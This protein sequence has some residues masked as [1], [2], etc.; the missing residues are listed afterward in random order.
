MSQYVTVNELIKEIYF[1]SKI[2]E[3]EIDGISKENWN[4]LDK[5]KNTQRQDHLK[6]IFYLKRC[7]T[8]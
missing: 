5:V 8:L 3:R 2:D 1:I 6:V 7:L 4:L